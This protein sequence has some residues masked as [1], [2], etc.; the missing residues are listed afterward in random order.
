MTIYFLPIIS[1]VMFFSVVI[2][3][4]KSTKKMLS[5]VFLSIGIFLYIDMGL[6]LQTI[7]SM[8]YK[9][10]YFSDPLFYQ[11]S[12][13]DIIVTILSIFPWLIY[14]GWV[15]CGLAMKRTGMSSLES[16]GINLSGNRLVYFYIFAFLVSFLFAIQGLNNLFK[17]D[18]L[19]ASRAS[20]G[21]QYG[22]YIVFLF[23]P[24]A[25]LSFWVVS[26]Q[27]KTI[28]GLVLTVFLVIFSILSTAAIG[29]RTASLLPILVVLVFMLRQSMTKLLISGLF[30]I[31]LASALLPY[32]KWQYQDSSQNLILET[33][34]NDFYR[35]PTLSSVVDHLQEGNLDNILPFPGAGY[36][37]TV[38]FYVPRE[39]S[40]GIKGYSTSIYYTAWIENI[41]PEN[42]NW[43][44]AFNIIDEALLNF[45]YFGLIILFLVGIIF[46]V[47]DYVSSRHPEFNVPL[48]L[49]CIW[50][51]GYDSSVVLYIF[52]SMI[53]FIIPLSLVFVKNLRIRNKMGK[54]SIVYDGF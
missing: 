34:N 39:L 3:A 38:L 23:I 19:W 14:T 42:E 41:P 30:V 22:A 20:I 52:G 44:L 27:A 37:Y 29:Q 8:R 51:M 17:Y 12:N 5:L 40:L 33:L 10:Y 36:V 1:H 4:Y 46:R 7:F 25:I 26:N 9:N 32:F 21:E 31:V 35:V 45:S 47:F 53:I 11:S 15:L 24:L 49:S 13:I 48:S 16:K 6:I 18:S 54:I 2:S 43:G 28:I 50:V